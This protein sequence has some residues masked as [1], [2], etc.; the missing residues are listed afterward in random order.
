MSRCKQCKY[1]ICYS[2]DGCNKKCPMYM[3]N[4]GV[5]HCKCVA[6]DFDDNE[7]C[8]YFVDKETDDE[9]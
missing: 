2:I 7:D 5:S 6:Y 9:V 4:D 8:P 1:D 3:P